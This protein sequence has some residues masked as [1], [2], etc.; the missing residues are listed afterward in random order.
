M[1]DDLLAILAPHPCYGCGKIGT[2]LCDNCKYNIINEYANSCIACGKLAGNEGVCRSCSTPYVRGWCI[3]ERTNE[4]QMLIDGYKF[5]YERAAYRP[6]A[7]LLLNCIDQLPG[8]T[9]VVPISTI[10]S[11]I[12]QRGY[13]HTYLIAREFAR[14]RGLKLQRPLLRLTKSTQRNANRA[15]RIAQAKRAFCVSQ[16]L[17]HAVP[18]LLIDDVIT[19]GSTLTY[20]TL[21]MKAAGAREVWV[22]AIARQPLD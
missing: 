18:Y 7:D 15:T 5:Q 4:L 2:L 20:A 8:N 14:R 9:V 11:H 10:S 19:T 1:I 21:A 17:S 12:R 22:A 16:K 13:D 6:L 3:G